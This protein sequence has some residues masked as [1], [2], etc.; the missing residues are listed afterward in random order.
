MCAL[1]L[2]GGLTGACSS[3]GGGGGGGGDTDA[4]TTPD[5]ATDTATDARTDASTDV[6]S[7]APSDA[8]TDAPV[9]DP[10]ASPRDLTGM[11]PG[12]DGSLHVMGNSSSSSGVGVGMIPASC[13]MGAKGHAVVFQYTMRSTAVLRVSTANAGTST[14]FDTVVAVLPS[15]GNVATLACNDDV[16]QSDAHSTATTAA[17]VM[18][19]TRVFIAVGG[20][21]RDAASADSGAF[22]LTIQEVVPRASG[23]ACTATDICATGTHCL[24]NPTAPATTICVPDG[25]NGGACMAGACMTGLACAGTGVCRAPLALGAACTAS[26]ACPA[27]AHCAA[28]T[29]DGSLRRCLADGSL[30]AAC[31]ITGTACDMGTCSATMPT[32]T[33][34]GVCRIAV[35]AGDFANKQSLWPTRAELVNQLNAATSEIKKLA[36]VEIRF[37]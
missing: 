36:G 21:G 16:S 10:C 3:N 37:E 13:T 19:G 33:A 26:D 27:S 12:T 2:A 8:R 15:C 11:A 30:G 24:A 20:Y 35:A 5:T 23:A 29:P 34:P 22:E 14:D 1:L 28:V 7:D 4:S 31:R 6:R 17:T 18:M 9:V 25:T 32:A